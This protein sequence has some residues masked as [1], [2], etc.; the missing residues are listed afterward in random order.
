MDWVSAGSDGVHPAAA[1]IDAA[2]GKR[3]TQA[4]GSYDAI[5]VYL[6]LGMSDAG[7]PGQK[8]MLQ[9]LQ[10][11]RNYLRDAQTPP[12]EVDAKGTPV[13]ADGPPGFSAAVVPYLVASGVP[14]EAKVQTDRL[15]ATRDS[16]SSLYGHAAE[17]YD[18]NLALFSTGWS[19]QRFRFERDGKLR[20]RWKQ[21]HED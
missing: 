6:W 21:T 1:P 11:M 16:S 2:S 5:R 3:E 18:Q 15:A 17:Y 14:A 9:S 12:L 8:G 7:M 10:G 20:V 4:A 19:E 13:R